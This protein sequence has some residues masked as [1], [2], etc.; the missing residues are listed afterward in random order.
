MRYFLDTEFIEDGKTIELI[1][2]GIVCE[3]RRELYFQNLDCEFANANQWVQDNVYP[4]LWDFKWHPKEQGSP[5]TLWMP[6]Q[7]DVWKSPQTIAEQF[8]A[9]V[10]HTA[11]EFWGYYADYDWVA[12]NQLYG[13][14]V[15]HPNNWPYYCRDLRQCLDEHKMQD[16][17]QPDDAPH[18]ALMDAR[19]IKE[20]WFRYVKGFQP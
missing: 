7:R 13:S 5:Y 6:G 12:L 2:I 17:K 10:R 9:F 8:R 20:T 18:H 19:W 11:V 3:D 15:N 4:H 14:M 1:S 16:V